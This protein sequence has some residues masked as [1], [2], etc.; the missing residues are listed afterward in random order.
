MILQVVRS[1]IVQVSTQ[2]GH[3]KHVA[4]KHPKFAAMVSNLSVNVRPAGCKYASM[5][6]VASSPDM[7]QGVTLCL[8]S[9][10]ELCSP[11]TPVSPTTLPASHI[12]VTVI[13][14]SDACGKLVSAGV[15][16]VSTRAGLSA[17]G[18]EDLSTNANGSPSAIGGGRVDCWAAT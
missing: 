6:C 11:P 10:A 3:P 8:P 16:G 7:M 17:C 4:L 12:T 18:S 1:L 14:L 9:A 5:C 13:A 15:G 2:S